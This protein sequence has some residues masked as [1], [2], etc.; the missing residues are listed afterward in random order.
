MLVGVPPFSATPWQGLDR[1]LGGSPEFRC[2]PLWAAF[3]RAS[4]ANGSRAA[5]ERRGYSVLICV[6]RASEPQKGA[7]ES[8]RELRKERW[9]QSASPGR[10]VGI[11][12]RSGAQRNS[13]FGPAKKGKAPHKGRRRRAM[14]VG[15]TPFSATPLAGV[16]S[17]WNGFPELRCASLRAVIRRA[18]GAKGVPRGDRAPRLQ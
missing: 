18:S 16:G 10:G 14:L 17:M 9:N 2:A 6:S 3:R 4:G 7:L 1:F 13:G 11:R 12:A 8:M 5:T 15:A